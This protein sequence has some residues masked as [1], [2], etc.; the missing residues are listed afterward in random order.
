[1]GGNKTTGLTVTSYELLEW[2]RRFS[3]F[4]EGNSK[5]QEG[6]LGLRGKHWMIIENN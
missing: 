3:D 2:A 5:W 4:E 6:I 1:M